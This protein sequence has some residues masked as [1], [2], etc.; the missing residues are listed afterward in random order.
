MCG[1]QVRDPD[2][3]G[4]DA[5]QHPALL[6]GDER[7][8][9]GEDGELHDVHPEDPRHQEVHI[10]EAHALHRLVFHRDHRRRLRHGE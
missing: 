9:H 6:V 3:S 1:Q 4:H 7:E 10:A 2:G 8:G 5:A